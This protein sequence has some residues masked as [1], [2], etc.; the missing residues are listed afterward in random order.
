MPLL[1]SVESSFLLTTANGT[2]QRIYRFLIG[3]D[4]PYTCKEIAQEL[5]LDINEVE[6]VLVEG[7]GEYFVQPKLFKWALKDEI[8]SM[9]SI[10]KS[11]LLTREKVKPNLYVIDQQ[12]TLGVIR[13]SLG[14]GFV[15]YWI[16]PDREIT[17]NWDRDS[18]L[19]EY[20]SVAPQSLIPQPPNLGQIFTSCSSRTATTEDIKILAKGDWIKEK[21]NPFCYKFNRW[22]DDVCI[23]VWE[24][25]EFLIPQHLL[26][27][28]TEINSKAI[29]K[30]KDAK[31]GE[32]LPVAKS[33]EIA[34]VIKCDDTELKKVIEQLE[35]GF[36]QVTKGKTMTFQFSQ[37]QA[38]T[39][40][41]AQLQEQ[42]NQLTASIEPYRECEQKANDLL[43]QVAEHAQVM[44]EKG[45]DERSLF[46]WSSRI[47]FQITGTELEQRDSEATKVLQTEN[48]SLVEKIELL[49]QENH[50]LKGQLELIRQDNKGFLSRIQQLESQGNPEPAENKALLT[51]GAIV[52]RADGQVGNVDYIPEPYKG[53]VS[54]NF[55]DGRFNY[56]ADELKII[57]Q[58]EEVE[59]IGSDDVVQIISTGEI[60]TVTGLAYGNVI[61]QIQGNEFNIPHS[62]LRLVSANPDAEVQL[63]AQEFVA[64]IK[65][66]KDAGAMTSGRSQTI[67]WEQVKELCQGEVKA[68]REI[69][70][71]CKTKTQKDW[72]AGVPEL[73]A[74]YINRTGD[75]AD[76][77][78][79]GDSA[80]AKVEEL[81]KT[82]KQ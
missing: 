32:D 55:L 50:Q 40:Q 26:S 3:R 54:V 28:C 18:E 44:R 41:I 2:L 53:I 75:R 10:T 59:E 21:D 74:D 70:L 12:Q 20:L 4:R 80:K 16:K 9:E 33:P 61:V 52:Q 69:S 66:K 62:Q 1:P 72:F 46:D 58:G 34:P 14:F 45:V 73:L 6:K 79:I 56:H 57:S 47:C 43:E 81:L 11:E 49:Q 63:K 23:G 35:Q 82:T 13:Q 17:Y 30:F 8:D 67:A 71:A 15:V 5:Q 76:L 42:L 78:W 25:K 38:I 60:G 48:A 68:L 22:D 19:I 37:T 77:D 29:A 27:V 24:G 36:K 7:K 39:E 31:F 65:T 64:K 51:V